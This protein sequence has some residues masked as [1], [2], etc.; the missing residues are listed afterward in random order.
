MSAPA[1]VTMGAQPEEPDAQDPRHVV[2]NP[3]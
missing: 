3:L 1:F 2:T